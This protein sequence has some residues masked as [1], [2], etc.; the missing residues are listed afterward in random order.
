MLIFL[1]GGLCGFVTTIL[2]L[3][4]YLSIRLGDDKKDD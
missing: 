4:M 1:L 2:V 3:F